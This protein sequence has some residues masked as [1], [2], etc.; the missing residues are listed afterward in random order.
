MNMKKRL[1]PLAII[2]FLSITPFSHAAVPVTDAENIMQ[3]AK[4]LAET[5]KVVTNT[6]QQIQL[7]L[8]ELQAWPKAQ[9]DRL[10]GMVDNSLKRIEAIAGEG[11]TGVLRLPMS[12]PGT[13]ANPDGS[14]TKSYM[15]IDARKYF[16]AVFPILGG[17]FNPVATADALRAAQ[18]AGWITL[19]ENNIET[20]K[21]IQGLMVESS[22]VMNDIATLTKLG[23]E[24]VG[25][26]QSAQ[27]SNQINAA[28]SRL[29]SINTVLNAMTGQQQ[30][31]Q[32]QQELQN[33]QNEEKV[34]QTRLESE[35][36]TSK[37]LVEEGQKAT[38]EANPM[39]SFI[40]KRGIIN[41]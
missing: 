18:Q 17:K 10:Q 41:F 8:Q 2:S 28:K 40:R 33:K 32:H 20:I 25:A 9:L 19:S 24:A 14:D 26:K 11:K 23:N 7:Q 12:M 29:E 6:A 38:W 13:I 5:V 35:T 34:L 15:D 21:K 37:K 39:E 1:L 22:K 3:Q 16:E 31:M 4:T 30:I 27:I 36:Q